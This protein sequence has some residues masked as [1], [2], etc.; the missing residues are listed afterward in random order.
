MQNLKIKLNDYEVPSIKDYYSPYKVTFFMLKLK[1]KNNLILEGI[2][3]NDGTIRA[4][5]VKASDHAG[6][7]EEKAI[8]A[9]YGNTFCIPLGKMF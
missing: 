4:S 9:A 3:L 8:V 6:T 1:R 7:D 5:Q 2:N